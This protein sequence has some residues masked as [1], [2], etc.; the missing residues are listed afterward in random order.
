MAKK[1]RKSKKRRKKRRKKRS[2]VA[3]AMGITRKG[4]P[5]KHRL[6]PKG[7]AKNEHREILSEEDEK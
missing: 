7:G 2:L 4:G 6:E 1:K 5:M 3:F